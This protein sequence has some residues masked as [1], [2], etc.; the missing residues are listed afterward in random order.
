MMMVIYNREYNRPCGIQL[1][2]TINNPKRWP[3]DDDDN[4]GGDDD[5]DKDGD[6]DGD[7]GD[8]GDL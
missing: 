7:D 1:D 3:N 8:D 2:R 5:G 6:N 4:D